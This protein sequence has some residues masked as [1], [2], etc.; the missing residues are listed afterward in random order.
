[1]APGRERDLRGGAALRPGSVEASWPAARTAGRARIAALLLGARTA[2]AGVAGCGH[3]APRELRGDSTNRRA[4]SGP[5]SAGRGPL[6]R[7]WAPPLGGRGGRGGGGRGIATEGVPSGGAVHEGLSSPPPT[8]QP[9]RESDD[10]RRPSRD[11]VVQ[12]AGWLG[13][14]RESTL[15]GLYG[16]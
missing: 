6:P 16:Y 2:R 15:A 7:E 9:R 4:P 3:G 11:R 14:V 5:H 13:R 12:V 8:S 1:G 10:S